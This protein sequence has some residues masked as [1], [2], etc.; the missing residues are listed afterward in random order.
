MP[1]NSWPIGV[2]WF[3]GV[4]GANGGTY[5]G[6]F[7][8]EARSG[9]QPLLPAGWARETRPSVV[10]LTSPDAPL[11]TTGV[12]VCD[13]RQGSV[14]E[15]CIRSCAAI[16]L[17]APHLLEPLDLVKVQRGEQRHPGYWEYTATGP[18]KDGGAWLTVSV[19][20]DGHGLAVV[21]TR[22]ASRARSEELQRGFVSSV[23]WRR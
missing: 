5:F 20:C 8:L 9:T 14:H 19:L 13:P 11:E 23:H 22:A 16:S 6:Q 12:L 1:Q 3:T 17:E 4:E 7:I 18:F 21:G 2:G 10:N 15:V